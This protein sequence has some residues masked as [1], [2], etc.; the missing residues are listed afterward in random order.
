MPSFSAQQR[1]ACSLLGAQVD[2]R[3]APVEEYMYKHEAS[4]LRRNQNS[5]TIR[6]RK[7]YY[8]TLNLDI[9]CLM[10]IC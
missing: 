5:V 4:L 8:R 2:W 10:S 6:G 7:V 1:Y 3:A 9:L